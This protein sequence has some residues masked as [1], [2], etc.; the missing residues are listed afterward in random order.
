MLFDKQDHSGA[1][2]TT[3]RIWTKLILIVGASILISCVTIATTSLLVFDKGL[4][5]D[6]TSQLDFTAFGVRHTLLDW[7]TSLEG[8]ALLLSTQSEMIAAVQQQNQAALNR[9]ASDGLEDL[10]LDLMMIADSQGVVIHDGGSGLGAG[11]RLDS[12]SVVR[13]ALGGSSSYSMEEIASLGYYVLAASPVYLDNYNRGEGISGCVLTGF[14]LTEFPSIVQ[15]SYNVESTVFSGDTRIAT[16]ITDSSG[17]SLKGTKLSN[18]AIIEAVLKKGE[19]YKGENRIQGE[20]YLSMYFPITSKDGS[21]TGMMFIAESIATINAI[22]NNTIKFIIPIIIVIAVVFLFICGSFMKW[23]MTRID[24]VA[25]ALK[26]MATGEADLTKR[27]RLLH[28]DEIG[29]LAINFNDFCNK[30]QQIVLEIKRSKAELEGAGGTLSENTQNTVSAITQIIANIDGIHHQIST[31]NSTVETTAKTVKQIS[32]D[33]TSLNSMI[34]NQSA[35]I[36]QASSAVE[37]M[38]SNISSVNH[39]V[40]K[41]AESFNSL[42][43]NAA[44]GFKK[45]KDVNERIQLIQR[46]SQML[47][48][49][50][51]AISNIAA[52]TNLLAMNAAIEA[53]HAGNA[54]KGFSV[55][56]DEIRKLSETSSAQSKTISGQL[57]NIQ[58]SISEVVQ[59]STDASAAL[60]TMSNRIQ[61]TD[62]L[63]VQIK[64]A[65]AEQDAGSRQIR[66]ALQNMNESS[67]VVQSASKDMA[68][69]NTVIL[70]EMQALQNSSSIMSQGMSE[71]STGAGKIH[72]TGIALGDVS[73]QLKAS[74]QKIGGQI[75]LF[76][77]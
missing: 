11:T 72:E 26:E 18:T 2:S 41:M 17:K 73:H 9:L 77:A 58:D 15:Q 20:D 47:H 23:M 63:V 38:I 48:E 16:T 75:D 30:L 54:G 21:I 53:A 60:T 45:Q 25:H 65:M 28:R 42:T 4:M 62:T 46:Q 3:M 55:V 66:E 69:Q 1:P 7:Q 64:S 44:E 68:E 27:V 59:A 14:S 8:D 13:T 24:N 22:R 57:K 10:G 36:S 61:E 40:D 43:T 70:G 34:E 35:G 39:S 12:L 33:I 56:A 31:Q 74:I 51:A 52:Q 32:E 67:A 49:A 19:T 5:A 37:E 50:N 71:M 29:F 76:T 6:T